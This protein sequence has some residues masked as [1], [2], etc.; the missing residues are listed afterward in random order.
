MEQ[1]N[2]GIKKYKV[3]YTQGAFDMF[4]IGHLNVLEAAKAQCEYLIVGVNSDSLI[5]DYK[6]KTPIIKE[7]ERCRIVGSLKVVDRV[8]IV[9]TLDKIQLL[10]EIH[11]DVIFIGSDWKGNP[12]WEKTMKDLKEYGV[13]GVFLPH[14]DGISSSMLRDILNKN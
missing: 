11:F 9:N 7:D 6:S 8:L 2:D 12:R 13:D 1:K 10:N 3:G 5:Q 14:T 4:H